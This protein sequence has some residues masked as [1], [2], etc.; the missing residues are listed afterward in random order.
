MQRLTS[1]QQQPNSSKQIVSTTQLSTSTK[2]HVTLGNLSSKMQLPIK[3][4][5]LK[6]HQNS[7]SLKHSVATVTKI[8][9]GKQVTGN[10]LQPSTSNKQQ[11]VSNQLQPLQVNKQNFSSQQVSQASKQSINNQLQTSP[12]NNKQIFGN[13]H[14]LSSNNKQNNQQSSKLPVVSVSDLPLVTKQLVSQSVIE[15]NIKLKL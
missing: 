12:T 14:Q 5:E 8:I 4:N 6:E 7:T 3:Q 2:Q 1:H 10:L 11:T 9:P 15:V 13:Q